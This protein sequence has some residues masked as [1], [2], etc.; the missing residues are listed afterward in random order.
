MFN[1][2][3]KRKGY[4]ILML[5]LLL[6]ITGCY[7]NTTNESDPMIGTDSETT[8]SESSLESE[9][10]TDTDIEGT[11][12]TNSEDENPSTDIVEDNTPEI[13]EGLI[14]I[15]RDTLPVPQNITE[16]EDL[17]YHK[18]IELPDLS[19]LSI[20]FEDILELAEEHKALQDLLEHLYS[21]L[22]NFERHQIG[23]VI[24]PDS[25]YVMTNKLNHLP[26]DYAPENLV[27]PEVRATLAEDVDKRY[28][29]EEMATALEGLFNA[30]E[31]E[32][33]Y[34]FCASGYRS[35]AT[36]EATYQYHVDTKGQEAADKVSAKPGHS[37]HQTGLAMDVTCED[38]EFRLREAL[39]E[40]PEGI[41]IREHAHEYGLIIRYPEFS[42]P[43]VGYSY[44]PWHLR[45]V[46]VELATFLYEYN[47]TLEELYF[48]IQQ[49]M[50]V[51]LEE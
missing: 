46:G 36:Q 51:Y 26:S 8:D 20:T 43:I 21:D 9:T 14:G 23:E 42:E 32:G 29:R 44:E 1:I 22:Y 2:H 37:E 6:T 10:S 28:V 34:L 48:L 49:T 18:A 31:E 50:Y 33:L 11:E 41:Y 45:Y 35:Y 4:V 12:T 16:V 3:F 27:I 15:P 47:L 17:T 5:I 30:A 24:T 25:L 19:T 39:G 38:V 7:F 13:P 40:L